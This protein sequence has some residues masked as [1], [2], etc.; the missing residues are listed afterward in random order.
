MTFTH[1]L[2]GNFK[3]KQIKCD[4]FYRYTSCCFISPLLPIRSHFIRRSRWSR[5]KCR[6]TW[7]RNCFTTC[8]LNKISNSCSILNLFT[9]QQLGVPMKVHSRIQLNLLLD[10]SKF[11]SRVK[12]FDNIVLPIVWLEISVE[13]LTPGLI[14]LLHLLFNILPYVQVGL[15][16]VLCVLGVSLFAVA[17]ISH[18]FSANSKSDYDPK[19]DV[20]YS[21]I[22]W[23]PNIK[24]EFEKYTDA[25]P[26]YHSGCE[27]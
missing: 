14:I 19:K 25:E 21:S 10:K 6:K 23:F 20:K 27:V 17:A 13:K 12:P 3:L 18:C 8:K 2:L 5:T 4:I 9:P 11:N 16:C 24:K 7:L 22:Y 1:K 15:V 26:K